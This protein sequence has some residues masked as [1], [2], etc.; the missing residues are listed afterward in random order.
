MAAASA[1]LSLDAYSLQKRIIYTK[2]RARALLAREV[3]LAGERLRRR[4]HFI[5]VRT[6]DI[7][8]ILWVYYITEA[9]DR[10]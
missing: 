5:R 2:R 4:V 10:Q 7:R 1:L 9:T 3:V 6:L 8:Y